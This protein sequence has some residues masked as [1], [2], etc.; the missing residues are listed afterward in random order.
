MLFKALNLITDKKF[1]IFKKIQ[2]TLAFYKM[3]VYNSFC[4]HDNGLSPSGKALILIPAFRGS[5]PSSPA[6]TL[7]F[8]ARVFCLT[9][10]SYRIFY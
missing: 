2:K 4:C 1:K 10:N 7:A 3:I 6:C 9:G 5:N 8:I